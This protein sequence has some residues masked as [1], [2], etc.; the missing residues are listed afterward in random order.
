VVI[1]YLPLRPEGCNPTFKS[2]RD[3]VACEGRRYFIRVTANLQIEGS[4]FLRLALCWTAKAMNTSNSPTGTDS[5]VTTSKPL[6]SA[7]FQA[8]KEE[9][10]SLLEKMKRRKERWA[11]EEAKY[12]PQTVKIVKR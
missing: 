5:T 6:R 2:F 7:K 8:L 4:G 3:G 9:G 12:F 11:Q 1:E 10:D